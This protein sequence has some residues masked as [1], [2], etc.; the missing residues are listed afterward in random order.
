MTTGDAEELEAAIDRIEASAAL[1]NSLADSFDC[2]TWVALYRVMGI[3]QSAV[4]K[5]Q[6]KAWE[7][8]EGSEK[9]KIYE[10][11]LHLAQGRYNDLEQRAKTRRE[12]SRL[13]G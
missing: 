1:T 2:L 11:M 12:R 5:Y 13:F 7:Y 4:V 6:L 10:H 9:R 3:T 8:E